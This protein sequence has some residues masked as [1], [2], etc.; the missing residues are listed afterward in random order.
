MG[1]I[2]YKHVNTGSI[3]KPTVGEWYSIDDHLGLPKK[4]IENCNDWQ[5]VKE[6]K[7]DW[8][9]L[10]FIATNTDLMYNIG[11]IL[12]RK[13]N[14]RFGWYDSTQKELIESPIH[15]INQVK[16]ADGTVFTLDEVTSLGRISGFELYGNGLGMY[17]CFEN[18]L[19]KADINNIQKEKPKVV[20]F[21]TEDG[22]NKY[23]G[24]KCWYVNEN[25]VAYLWTFVS[26]PFSLSGIKYFDAEEKAKDYILH[27]KPINI[28]ANE[29]IEFV[30]RNGG[31][32]VPEK[33]LKLFKSKINL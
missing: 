7:P 33:I 23:E 14:G 4:F 13:T 5:L 18:G 16:V 31:S 2:K 9:I 19:R 29:I 3:A 22:V 6:D 30:R 28:S 10:S 27:N 8:E 1:D 26:K 25:M 11:D 17:A 32:L 24:D 12:A 15:K 21:T 20:L